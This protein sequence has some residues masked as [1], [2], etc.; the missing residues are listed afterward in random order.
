MEKFVQT[1]MEKLGE[2]Y[3]DTKSEDSGK[4]MFNKFAEEKMHLI[5]EDCDPKKVEQTL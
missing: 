3:F 2:W 4:F 1:V 5:P